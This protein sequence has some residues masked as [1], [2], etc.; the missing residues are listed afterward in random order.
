MKQESNRMSNAFGILQ[1][2][3]KAF[4]LPIALLPAA[5]ILLGVG[6][7][8]LNV[9]ALENPPAIY[10]GLISFINLRGVTVA[11]TVMRN[12][13]DIVFGNLPLLFAIG[14]AVGLANSDKGTAALAGQLVSLS[15]TQLFQRC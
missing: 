11:L 6:G 14:I 7:A 10:E 12:V 1:R 2:V 4:M 3:G 9:A 5:G 13:G 15:C 8:L